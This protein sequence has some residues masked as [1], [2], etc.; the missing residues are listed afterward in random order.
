MIEV[1]LLAILCA[2]GSMGWIHVV[3]AP[4]GILEALPLIFERLKAPQR[5]IHVLFQC[6]KCMAGQLFMWI[7]VCQFIHAE[8]VKIILIGITGILAST[9]IAWMIDKFHKRIV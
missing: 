3:V 7:Y 2:L 6:E 9:F 4:H 1:I 8:V 5:F